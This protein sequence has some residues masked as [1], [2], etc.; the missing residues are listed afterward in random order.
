MSIRKGREQEYLIHST[1][2]KAFGESGQRI[3][4]AFEWWMQDTDK[5][6]ALVELDDGESDPDFVR[7]LRGFWE[8]SYIHEI[9]GTVV[10]EPTELLELLYLFITYWEY[11]ET[12]AQTL[13]IFEHGILDS[14]V[15]TKI[16]RLSQYADKVAPENLME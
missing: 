14:L 9:K 4:Q 15:F 7:L 13:T 10:L 8:Y 16:N 11:G 5:K 12:L 1:A 2:L 6:L 3:I